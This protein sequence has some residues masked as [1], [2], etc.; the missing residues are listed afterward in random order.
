MGLSSGALQSNAGLKPT[1]FIGRSLKMWV[2]WILGQL[3]KI[4]EPDVLLSRIEDAMM[5]RLCLHSKNKGAAWVI[6]IT[7]TPNRRRVS[8]ELAS[9]E[10]AICCIT[11]DGACSKEA[12]FRGAS[13][14]AHGACE[15]LTGGYLPAQ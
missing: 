10:P 4:I 3:R 9:P 2:E 8:A 15:D 5:V 12:Y 1:I 13:R 11:H 6:N 14:L 7:H